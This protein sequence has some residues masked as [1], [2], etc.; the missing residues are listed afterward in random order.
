MFR[1]L[2]KAA[3]KYQEPSLSQEFNMDSSNRF[4]RKQ[5]RQI[6]NVEI[7]YHQEINMIDEMFEGNR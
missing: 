3:T 5:G 7:M 4:K 6:Q 1:S 2:F